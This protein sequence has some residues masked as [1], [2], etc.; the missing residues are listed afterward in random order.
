M[1]L[2]VSFDTVLQEEV[3]TFNASRFREDLMSRVRAGAFRGGVHLREMAIS[4]SS[5]LVE[6]I[7]VAERRDDLPTLARERRNRARAL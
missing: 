4:A 1:A 2:R 5:V 3:A 7:F 6:T